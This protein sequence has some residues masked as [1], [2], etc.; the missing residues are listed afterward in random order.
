MQEKRTQTNV[1][2][3]GRRRAKHSNLK[4]EYCVI[5]KD[6]HPGWKFRT[7]FEPDVWIV[8][9]IDGT[10][11]TARKGVHQVTRNVLWLQRVEHRDGDLWFGLVDES[12]EELEGGYV[13]QPSPPQE[14]RPGN[15]GGPSR[16]LEGF[17]F[18]DLHEGLSRVGGVK[19][20]TCGPT[21]SPAKG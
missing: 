2:A 21:L 17:C 19:G 11:V 12:G 7:P 15:D 10:M 16:D 18:R 3:S 20:T 14:C 6:C 13:S 5:L 8:E 9:K 1:Q 4:V